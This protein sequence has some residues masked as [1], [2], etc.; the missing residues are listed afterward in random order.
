MNRSQCTHTHTHIT[1]VVSCTNGTLLFKLIIQAILVEGVLTQEV[2][3][4]Q[5]E[6]TLALTTLH[7]LEDLGTEK[8]EEEE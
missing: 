7:Y 6:A 4:R 5:G 8:E 2:D 3:S 1:P